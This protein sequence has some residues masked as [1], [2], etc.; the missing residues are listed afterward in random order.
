MK[1]KLKAVGGGEGKNSLVNGKGANLAR[2][3]LELIIFVIKSKLP[4][5]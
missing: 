2:L 4:K 1:P 3:F 5:W